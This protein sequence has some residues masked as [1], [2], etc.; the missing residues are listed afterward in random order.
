MEN[1]VT[2]EECFQ[3]TI[4]LIESTKRITS[5]LNSFEEEVTKTDTLHRQIGFEGMAHRHK[6]LLDA[7]PERY[8]KLR[9]EY[10]EASRLSM[11]AMT[12]TVDT[13]IG[14]SNGLRE[15]RRAKAE[16]SN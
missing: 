5:I 6:L 16:M 4:D 7:D 3:Q 9:D 2:A 10:T 8:D 12:R 15:I 14:I 1:K 11:I 13:I